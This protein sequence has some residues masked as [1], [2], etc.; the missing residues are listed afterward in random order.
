MCMPD[1]PSFFWKGPPEGVVL[2]RPKIRMSPGKS[3]VE[4]PE[5]LRAL[6]RC[7]VDRLCADGDAGGLAIVDCD[8]SE[9]PLG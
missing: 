4:R 9:K 1:A 5:W 2:E 3:L 8:A 7:A 6:A